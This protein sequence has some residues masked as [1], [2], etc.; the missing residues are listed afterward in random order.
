MTKKLLYIG[1]ALSH[2][3]ST[4]TSVEILSE[5][6][7]NHGYIVRIAS[8]QPNKM[9]RM[10]DMI[11]RTIR[12]ARATD[13]VLIDTYSTSNF[14]YAVIIGSLCR[15]LGLSYIPILRGGDLPNRLKKSPRA[16]KKLF[17]NAKIN[18]AP[19]QY[20]F[21]AFQKEGISNLTCIPNN[22]EI[23]K[24][25]YVPREKFSPK[26]LWVR[27]FSKIY[28]P[29]MALK[30][31]E[32][33][34][35]D[36]PQTTLTMVGPEKDESFQE[37]YAFAKAKNLT[38]KFTGLL[39]KDAWIALAS[40]HDIF[41]STTNFDNT[42]VSVIEAMALGLPVVSTNVGGMPYLIDHEKD[43][44]LTPPNDVLSFTKNCKRILEDTKLAK[45]IAKKARKKAEG[46]DW[47]SVKKRWDEVLS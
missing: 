32:Q 8:G 29:L 23:K 10:L 18:I 3:G 30:I 4:V 44:L 15:T 31:L 37:C 6:L 1:N 25:G 2:K 13:R 12:Y 19:S 24:Y 11:W 22:I 17:A 33:L 40:E 39:S 41:I 7:K 27:S 5:L 45:T 34:K 20:I 47:T 43:G 38:V 14:W 26:L 21:S 16:A 9:V 46:F 36:Y 28:N 42:P 35:N